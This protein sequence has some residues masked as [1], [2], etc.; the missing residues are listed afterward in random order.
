MNSQIFPTRQRCLPFS[1]LCPKTF[2]SAIS[3]QCSFSIP[4]DQVTIPLFHSASLDSYFTALCFTLLAASRLHLQLIRLARLLNRTTLAVLQ[5]DILLSA[6]KMDREYEVRIKVTRLLIRINADQ[7]SRDHHP[8]EIITQHVMHRHGTD[9]QSRH[10]L[11]S[12]EFPQP[13]ELMAEYPAELPAGPSNE[14]PFDKN[15]Y[16]EFQYA[17]NRFEGTELLR[18]AIKDFR[19]KPLKSD[20]DKFYVYTQVSFVLLVSQGIR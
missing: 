4:T 14:N 18:Q 6:P 19:E 11:T 2:L 9:T 17:M 10:W 13:E 8:M 16:L 20:R 7:A 5:P 1:H 3:I 12:P 15:A